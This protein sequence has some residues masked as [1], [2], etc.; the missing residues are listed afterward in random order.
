MCDASF[1]FSRFMTGS[2]CY[3]QC[4]VIWGGSNVNPF[5]IPVG[6][7]K[8][9]LYWSAERS[10]QPR[11]DT[12]TTFWHCVW[13]DCSLLCEFLY[14][15]KVTMSVPVGGC[16]EKYFVGVERLPLHQKRH[17]W[18]LLIVQEVRI[19]KSHGQ[20]YLIFI[21]CTVRE[22]NHVLIWWDIL[23]PLEYCTFSPYFEH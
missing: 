12:R 8:R 16:K 17:I 15:Q 6:S 9:T 23:P 4:N 13:S 14:N 21:R 22:N 10:G 1:L 3:H 7:G 11:Y 20:K 5:K 18:H 2:I 19:W